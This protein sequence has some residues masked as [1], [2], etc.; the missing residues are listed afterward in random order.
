MM[1][2]AEGELLTELDLPDRITE[3]ALPQAASGAIP[4]GLTMEQLERLAITKTLQECGGNRTHAAAR[5]GISVRTLQRK[6]RQYEMD[7]GRDTTTPG[8]VLTNA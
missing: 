2:L 1:V 8:D 6:L 3:E 5:L 4:S 7:G